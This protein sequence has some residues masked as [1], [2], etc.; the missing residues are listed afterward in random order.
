MIVRVPVVVDS[1]AERKRADDLVVDHK[2]EE[3]DHKEVKE[4]RRAAA[5]VLDRD[6]VIVLCEGEF[7]NSPLLLCVS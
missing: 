2:E 3:A 5:A 6:S 1:K 4:D 7:Y